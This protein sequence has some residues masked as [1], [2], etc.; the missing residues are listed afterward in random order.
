[1]H[2][3]ETADGKTKNTDYTTYTLTLFHD[4]THI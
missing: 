4:D 3:Y 2:N 1:M